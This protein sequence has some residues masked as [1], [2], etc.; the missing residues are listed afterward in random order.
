MKIAFYDTKPYDKIWFEKMIDEYGFPVKFFE[1]K[2]NEDTAILSR[3]FDVVCIF[4]N[5]LLYRLINFRGQ[6]SN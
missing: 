6:K 3:G 2:L 5:H 4:V 1:H